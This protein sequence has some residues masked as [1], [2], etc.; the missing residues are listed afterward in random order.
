MDARIPCHGVAQTAFRNDDDNNNN[1]S[2]ESSLKKYFNNQHF[3]R[4]DKCVFG[5][6]S[7][8]INRQN[9]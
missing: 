8:A 6:N 9:T 3:L 5:Q 4:G 7:F 1:L 2:T